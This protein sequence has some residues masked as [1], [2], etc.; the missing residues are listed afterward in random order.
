MA[1]F[2]LVLSS[3]EKDR[4]RREAAAR[5]VSM[6]R[7]VLDAVFG[8]ESPDQVNDRLDDVERRLGRLEE[9]AG[10]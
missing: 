10:L 1:R 5:G 3:E 6:K 2:E 7:L 9:M 8:A 4:L